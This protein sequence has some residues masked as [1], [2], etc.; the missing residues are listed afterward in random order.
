[1]RDY[2]AADHA[3][4]AARTSNTAAVAFRIVIT[5]T[6]R[7]M[8][9]PPMTAIAATVHNAARAPKPTETGE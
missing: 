6:K 3:A 8:P 5:L 7:G 1:M 4:S 9:F 2:L